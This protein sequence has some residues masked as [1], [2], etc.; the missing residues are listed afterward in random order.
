MTRAVHESKWDRE[1]L[2]KVIGT[3]A[4]MCPNPSGNL[5][6]AWIEAEPDP[7]AHARDPEIVAMDDESGQPAT[8]KDRPESREDAIDPRALHRIRITRADLNSY[9][10][11]PGCPRCNDLRSGKIHSNSN[12]TEECR[13]RIYSEWENNRNPKWLKAKTELGIDDTST[14]LPPPPMDNEVLSLI[15]I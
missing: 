3:P 13:Y 5:D 12:H 4:L 11:S 2:F 9:G 15:H 1:G 7:H 10:Y 14:G 6:A 8:P